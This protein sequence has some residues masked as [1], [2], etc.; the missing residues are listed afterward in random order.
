LVQ[1][2]LY[3]FVTGLDSGLGDTSLQSSGVQTQD[4][5]GPVEG[6]L[7]V[8][9]RSL[10]NSGVDLDVTELKDTG[11][12]VEDILLLLGVKVH[13]A[14]G[15][16]EI[17]KVFGI[18]HTV[19]GVAARV[20]QEV[21][22]V[23]LLDVKLLLLLFVRTGDELVED[24]EGPLVLLLSDDSALLEEVRHDRSTRDES[25]V[26]ELD[27]DELSETRRVVVSQGLGVTE[28]LE[29]GVG[30]EHL[31]LELAGAAGA[32]GTTS[33]RSEVLDDLLRVLRLTSTR[34]SSDEDRLVDAVVQ[35]GAVSI[36]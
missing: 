23:G 26:V 24:V 8:D 3:D 2:G 20:L 34:L 25:G 16:L 6:V 32:G 36:V 17:G 10:S 11:D 9:D 18:V 12:D 14:H 7:V 31:L 5:G 29:D 19:D 1:V 4:L 27:L 15:L 22:G 30:L 21:V 33:D 35:H 13:D 28:R